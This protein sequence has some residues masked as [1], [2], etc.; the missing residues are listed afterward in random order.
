MFSIKD[1][2]NFLQYDDFSGFV[3]CSR[4]G[5]GVLRGGLRAGQ[6]RPVGLERRVRRRRFTAVRAAGAADAAGAERPAVARPLPAQLRRRHHE[7]QPAARKERKSSMMFPT[8]RPSG[9]RVHLT[10]RKLATRSR[11]LLLLV[12]GL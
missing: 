1:N 7:E 9:C 2:G 11:F 6:G 3:C 10:R 8:N 12:V 4:D 5:V